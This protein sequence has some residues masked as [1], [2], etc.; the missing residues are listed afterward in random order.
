M[1]PSLT[2]FH[3]ALPSGF[4]WLSILVLAILA[5]AAAVDAVKGRVPDPLIFIGLVVAVGGQG[6]A[7]D[8]PIAARHLAVG[9]GAGLA[10]WGGNELY[11]RL[12]KRDAFG[13]GDA[14]W[15]AL[16]VTQFGVLP[17]FWAWVIGA[18]LGLAWLGAA[19]LFGR[20]LRHVHFAPFLTLGLLAALFAR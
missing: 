3:L 19:R 4:G 14:K 7:N 20:R 10:L 5:T 16:A 15:T 13:M 2:S 1:L 8:W 18:W 9:L 11:Y 17:I 6:F 12:R